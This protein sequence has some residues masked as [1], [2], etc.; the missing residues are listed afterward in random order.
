MTV[1][2][3]Q[4]QIKQ[5]D[6]AQFQQLMAWVVTAEKDRR[7]AQPAV[8]K[9]Q[10]EIITEL[11]DAGKLEK[12]EAQPKSRLRRTRPRC[13]N[14]KTQAPTTRRCTTRAT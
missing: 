4:D 5:L 10:A 2:E 11:Q 8:E 7:A 14:G 13:R 9:A 1:A 3:L 12:P 6:D